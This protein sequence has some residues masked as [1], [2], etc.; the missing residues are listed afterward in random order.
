[1]ETVREKGAFA[2]RQLKK[3]PHV[4]IKSFLQGVLDDDGYPL[5]D[6]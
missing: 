2:P 6:K 3:P 5:F 1:M 4:W